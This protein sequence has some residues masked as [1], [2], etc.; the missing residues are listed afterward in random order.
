MSKIDPDLI[1]E[2][3]KDYKKPEN[4]IGA[5][6]LL[7]QAYQSYPGKSFGFGTHRTFRL[8]EKRHKKQHG[9]FRNGKSHKILK[10]DHGDMKTSGPRDREAVMINYDTQAL[11]SAVVGRKARLFDNDVAIRVSKP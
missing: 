5:N 7:K 11:R 8:R 1:N 2:L 10:T 3:L 6:G 9:N 4:I